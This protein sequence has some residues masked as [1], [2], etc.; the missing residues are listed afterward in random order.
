MKKSYNKQKVKNNGLQQ[1]Q[2]YRKRLVI[3]KASKQRL[4]MVMLEHTQHCLA[5]VITSIT[6]V[7]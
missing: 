2:T 7:P 6:V 5:T 1:K 3:K 4:V